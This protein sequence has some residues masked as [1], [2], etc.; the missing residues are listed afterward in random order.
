[1][2]KSTKLICNKED[3]HSYDPELYE[4]LNSF[5]NLI[6]KYNSYYTNNTLKALATKKPIDRKGILAIDPD[7]NKFN[8]FGEEFLR[9]IREHLHINEEWDVIDENTSTYMKIQ[10]FE[11]RLYEIV[12][13]KLKEQCKDDW[14]YD[15]IP[16]EI[17]RKAAEQHEISGGI[18]PKEY[19][20]Y[21]INLK[22]I[23]ISNWIL[24]APYIDKDNLGKKEFDKWF[25][26]LNNIRNKVSHRLRLMSDPL[27]EGDGQFIKEKSEWIEQVFNEILKNGINKKQIK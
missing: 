26:R 21:L 7:E 15:G 17:R 27:K 1:M 6:Y 14:W 8:S 5:R 23:I 19:C 24:F 4:K 16:L 10:E 11:E 25:N 12:Q 20:L 3:S 18:V 22:E 9:L 2:Q 13:F